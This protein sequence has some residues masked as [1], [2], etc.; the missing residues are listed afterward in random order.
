[1]VPAAVIDRFRRR[2]KIPN[3]TEAHQL[4]WIISP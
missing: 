2:M 3:C 4:E 1:M